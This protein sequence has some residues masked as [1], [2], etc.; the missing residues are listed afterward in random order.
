MN[1]HEKNKTLHL[2][3]KEF[4]FTIV[5]KNKRDEENKKNRYSSVQIALK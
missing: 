4:K 3:F 5:N 2:C 1:S